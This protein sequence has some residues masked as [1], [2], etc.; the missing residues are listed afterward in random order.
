MNISKLMSGIVGEI[1]GNS[2]FKKTKNKTKKKSKNETLFD[3]YFSQEAKDQRF[4]NRAEKF[5]RKNK[6]Y[7]RRKKHDKDLLKARGFLK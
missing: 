6:E 4:I 3:S 1:K 2:S 5:E 7:E